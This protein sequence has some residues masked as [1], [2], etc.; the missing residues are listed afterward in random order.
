MWPGPVAK[1][2]FLKIRPPLPSPVLNLIA[3][4]GGGCGCGNRRIRI[5]RAAAVECS[6]IVLQTSQTDRVG[7]GGGG[8]GGGKREE[9]DV[10]YGLWSGLKGWKMERKKYSL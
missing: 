5:R 4:S 10:N 3:G 6:S 1:Q 9:G 8:G 2:V 7:G